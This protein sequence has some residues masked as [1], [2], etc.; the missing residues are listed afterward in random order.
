MLS[1][2]ID[3]QPVHLVD[4]FLVRD[5]RPTLSVCVIP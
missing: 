5:Q 3:S 4:L 1:I 2:C